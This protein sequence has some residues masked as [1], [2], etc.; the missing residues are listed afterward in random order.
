MRKADLILVVTAFV[1]LFGIG[2]SILLLPQQS[3]SEE[4]NRALTTWI[5]PTL[6]ELAAVPRSGFVRS[7]PTSFPF[8][9]L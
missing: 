1:L 3:F 9:P 6:R 4:E 2:L 8:A 7:M 5:H